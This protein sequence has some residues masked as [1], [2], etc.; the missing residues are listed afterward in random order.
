MELWNPYISNP[1]S[2]NK[3]IPAPLKTVGSTSIMW[4]GQYFLYTAI[5]YSLTTRICRCEAPS[6]A[7]YRLNRPCSWRP[8]VGVKIGLLMQSGLWGSGQKK[9]KQNSYFKVW[10]MTKWCKILITLLQTQVHITHHK[11]HNTRKYINKK[12]LKYIHLKK[13]KKWSDCIAISVMLL[14]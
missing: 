3:P 4:L 6:I 11:V 12:K 13:K 1:S 8:V 5:S 14:Y 2:S 7:W 9:I 10:L